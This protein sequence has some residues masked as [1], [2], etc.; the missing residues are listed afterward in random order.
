[1]RRFVP[2]VFA[3]A[4]LS[5][6]LAAQGPSAAAH[7]DFSGTWKLDPKK[8]EGVGVPQ[9]MTLKVSKDS[10][11]LSFTRNATTSAGEQG[12]TMIVNLDGSPTK[13]TLVTQGLS[14]DLILKASWDGPAFV[15]KTNAN[16]GGQVLDQTDRWTL[17]PNGTTMHIQT[18]TTGA[19]QTMSLKMT[20]EKQ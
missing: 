4:T 8:S 20:L 1:M 12:S 15:I 11:V 2:I 16:I 10:K 18:T 17:D 6:P 7:P 13:N 14:V 3:L 9:S 5:V 19:N